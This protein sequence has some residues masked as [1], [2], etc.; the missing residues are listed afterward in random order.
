LRFRKL[1]FKPEYLRLI[2]E[3]RKKSTIRLEKKYRV[4]ETVYL[5]DTNGKIY[6]K[7]VIEDVIEKR[8]DELTERDAIIDGF[9]GLASLYNILRDIYGEIS[10]DTT[11]YIYYIKVLRWIR[12]P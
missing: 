12:N 9:N 1:K 5:S 4:G 8:F 2:R 10:G 6:G 3:G 11:I 7:A